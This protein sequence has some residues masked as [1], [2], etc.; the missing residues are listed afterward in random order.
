M[1][2][3]REDVDGANAL[4]AMILFAVVAWGV[5]AFWFFATVGVGRLLMGLLRWT[6]G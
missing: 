5:F 1:I 3:D 2:D 6:V 4:V